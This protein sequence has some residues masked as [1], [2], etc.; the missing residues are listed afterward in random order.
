M[1][2]R[3][4]CPIHC[5]KKHVKTVVGKFCLV[6]RYVP[7]KQSKINPEQKGWIWDS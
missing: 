4:E 7:N 5:R 1:E 6:V 3:E 2:K